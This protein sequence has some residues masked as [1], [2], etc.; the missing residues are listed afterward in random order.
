M[1]NAHS[2]KRTPL[3]LLTF[4]YPAETLLTTISVFLII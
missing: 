1:H 2:I 3:T 4:R